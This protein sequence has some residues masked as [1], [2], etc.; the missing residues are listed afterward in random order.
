MNAKSV[1][2]WSPSP[3]QV[4][5]KN[6]NSY[7]HTYAFIQPSSNQ[8]LSLTLDR[9]NINVTASGEMPKDLVDGATYVGIN[10]MNGATSLNLKDVEISV[11]ALNGYDYRDGD[12]PSASTVN[13][14]GGSDAYRNECSGCAKLDDDYYQKYSS[15]TCHIE[16]WCDGGVDGKSKI[17]RNSGGCGGFAWTDVNGDYRE[18]KPGLGSS[19]NQGVCAD[20]SY[21][22]KDSKWNCPKLWV[23]ASGVDFSKDQG[24]NGVGGAA[25]KNGEGSKTVIGFVP[26]TDRVPYSIYVK[27]DRSGARGYYGNPGVGG[28]G[29]AVYQ[30]WR[31]YNSNGTQCF[32]GTGGEGGCGGQ[33]GEAGGTGGSAI[34][35]VLRST[36]AVANST[37]LTLDGTKMIVKNGNGGK[38]QSGAGGAK[39]GSGGWWL[40]YA[41]CYGTADLCTVNQYQGM[42]GGGSGGGGG[43][44]GYGGGGVAGWAFPYVFDCA[45]KSVQTFN[46]DRLVTLYNCGFDVPAELTASANLYGVQDLSTTTRVADIEYDNASGGQM[47]NDMDLSQAFTSSSD[48]DKMLRWSCGSQG[49]CGSSGN[50]SQNC[51]G[52]KS[53]DGPYYR[54]P[55][56]AGAVPKNVD[57]TSTLPDDSCKKITSNG[58]K[59]SY[60]VRAFK[61]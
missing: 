49:G 48:G 59:T 12:H 61:E 43:A 57:K 47:D 52:N 53:E 19:N 18:G 39:G 16:R 34:G 40:A 14:I 20:M 35:I 1:F 10:G 3:K 15:N 44:G 31:G 23:T 46:D 50:G 45:V 37:R 24:R 29:G 36:S 26:E 38:P 51:G 42:G 30:C 5:V 4:K 54:M 28:G 8:P 60:I 55:G 33:G 41:R 58:T 7:I 2:T 56:G 25:G 17:K 21:H 22:K 9:I 6:N 32:A 11:T 27:S 13:G